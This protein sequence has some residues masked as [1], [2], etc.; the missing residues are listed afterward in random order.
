MIPRLII[1]AGLVILGYV[2]GRE[3]NRANHIHRRLRDARNR[4]IQRLS[5]SDSAA[6]AQDS[7]DGQPPGT[8]QPTMIKSQG[9]FEES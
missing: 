8:R 4:G 7:T 6:R 5:P 3:M 1:G 2:A 9:R